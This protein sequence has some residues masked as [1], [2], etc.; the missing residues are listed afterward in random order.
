M[1]LR[2]NLLY[3]ARKNMPVERVTLS[4]GAFMGAFESPWD[5]AM[6]H[7]VPNTCEC[8]CLVPPGPLCKDVQVVVYSDI[9]RQ[10]MWD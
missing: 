7:V 3:Y 9:L 8:K 10:S 2:E 5:D 1:P 4:R 6:F